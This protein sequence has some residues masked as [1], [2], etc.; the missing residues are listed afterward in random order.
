MT[1]LLNRAVWCREFTDSRVPY[2]AVRIPRSCECPEDGVALSLLGTFRLGVQ[3]LPVT[4]TGGSQRLVAFLALR[5]RRLN[6]GAA[7]GALWPEVSEAQAHANLRSA[8]W[9]L[10][11]VTQDVVHVNACE[12]ELADGVV[13]DYEEAGALAHQLT[14][15]G[16]CPSDAGMGTDA[17]AALSCDLLPDW[18]EDWALIEAEHWRQL[19]LHALESLAERSTADGRFAD[20]VEAAGAAIKADPLRESAQAALIRAHLA[21]GNQSEALR[22]FASYRCL[23]RKELGLDPSPHLLAL[24]RDLQR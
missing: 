7:A 24:V 17:I 20:A 14:V 15:D 3:T 8:I 12:I 5:G 1:S 19:R 11:K 6:R 18:Y 21:E 13:V 22:A 9:R 4:L 16:A 10:D 23:L 2:R